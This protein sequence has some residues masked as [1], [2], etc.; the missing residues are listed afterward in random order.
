LSKWPKWV[1]AQA[2]SER[3]EYSFG[4]VSIGATG[5]AAKVRDTKSNKLIDV[6]DYDAW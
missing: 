6:T 3:Y 2:L 1:H 4:E 5:F